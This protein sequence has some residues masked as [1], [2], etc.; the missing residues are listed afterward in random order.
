MTAPTRFISHRPIGSDDDHRPIA[1]L[2][3]L[4]LLGGEIRRRHLSDHAPRPRASGPWMSSSTSPPKAV[5]LQRRPRLRSVDRKAS[6]TDGCRRSTGPTNSSTGRM[7][8]N[9]SSN[10]RAAAGAYSYS[11]TRRKTPSSPHSRRFGETMRSPTRMPSGWLDNMRRDRHASCCS[12]LNGWPSRTAA[13]MTPRSCSAAH[14]QPCRS[15]PSCASDHMY[16]R[17]HGL[18]RMAQ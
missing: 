11:P 15:R 14:P 1:P 13:S 18:V 5:M 9:R 8:P 17:S 12:S 10:R 4:T 6:E 7:C 2:D 16:G 3:D